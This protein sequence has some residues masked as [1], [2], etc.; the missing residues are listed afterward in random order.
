MIVRCTSP[1]VDIPDVTVPAF[2]LR[3]AD[4]LADKP[5]LIDGP[6][7][8]TMTFGQL[9]EAIRRAATALHRRGFRKGDVFAIFSHNI[10]EYAVAF[11]A[12]ASLGGIVSTAN[13]LYTAGELCKQLKD[14]HA[15]FLI[16]APPFLEKAREAAAAAG[17]EDIYLFGGEAPGVRPFDELLDAPPD[18]PAVSI[19]AAE[20][21]VVL[22]YSSGTTGLP[23]GVMLT[24]RNLV[25]NLCQINGAADF[26]GFQERD[27]ILAVLPFFH[28]YGMVVILQL[29]LCNGATIVTMPRFDFEEFLCTTQKYPHHE[30]ANRAAHRPRHG[31]EP[32]REPVRLVERPDGIFWRGAARRGA[33]TAIIRAHWLSGASGVRH[34]RGEPGHAHQPDA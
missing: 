30:P 21:I 4:R 10:P 20:D 31:E 9:A 2:V 5:A 15:R 17:V 25:A 1:N 3:H 29:G 23:K 12:V 32:D 11:N 26:D 8:R 22:P 28:I 14:C 13:P 27:R 18:P 19:N 16:T 24:H 7:G 34:D 33:G 6:T